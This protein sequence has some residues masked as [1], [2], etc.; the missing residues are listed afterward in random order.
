MRDLPTFVVDTHSLYW[1]RTD[2]QRLSPTAVAVFRL[3]SLDE[4]RI[5]VP[6]IVVAE[7]YFLT[8]K[9]GFPIPPS[10]LLLDIMQSNE[11][12][13]S[14]LGRAQLE[15]MEEVEAIPE[16]HDRLIAAEAR[17]HQAPIISRDEALKASGVVEVI[18]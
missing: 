15:A 2:P 4:V 3:A 8:Q 7:L 9:V 6:A 5:I 1:F 17:V 11:F 18:W 12:V 14:E 13:F 16:M 10:V